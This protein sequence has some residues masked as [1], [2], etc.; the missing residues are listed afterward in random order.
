M[1][2]ISSELFE[3]ALVAPLDNA[4]R[5][6]IGTQPTANVTPTDLL[7]VN[8]SISA[9]SINSGGNAGLASA[10][11]P[12]FCGGRIAIVSGVV[13]SV[14]IGVAGAEAVMV[15]LSPGGAVV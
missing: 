8:G 6:Y 10:Y 4:N 5:L 7:T 14:V 12:I 3:R 9:T 1:S 2:L 13:V 15:A 11:N